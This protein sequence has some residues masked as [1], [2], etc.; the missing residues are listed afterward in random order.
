[1]GISSKFISIDVSLLSKGLYFINTSYKVPLKI[2][3]SLEHSITFVV[4]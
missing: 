4:L 1:M 2:Q 3:L